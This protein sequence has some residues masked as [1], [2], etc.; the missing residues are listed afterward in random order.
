MAIGLLNQVPYN[1]LTPR[2]IHRIANHMINGPTKT[3]LGYLIDFKRTGTFATSLRKSIISG[4]YERAYLEFI[5][6][7]V[8]PS[9]YVV[10][11]GAHEG[12]I[13]C[14]LSQI[15]EGGKVFSIEPNPENLAFLNRNVKLNSAAN[16]KVIEKAVGKEKAKMP[17]Y[18]STDLGANGS[19]I[20]FSY[21]SQDQVEVDVDTLDN[22]LA[23]LKRLNFLKVDTEGNELDVFLGAQQ[24]LSLHKPHICFEVSL[25]F[26]AYIE[27]SVD[28]L[29]N[30]LKKQ[31]YEL[32]VLKEGRLYEYKWLNERIVNMF[33]IHSSKKIELSEKGII[34]N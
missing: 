12:Y 30:L 24:I 3:R 4:S 32:F 26:W 33:A 15:V 9:D 29:F 20:P 21:F 31:G 18:C 23:D 22:L 11:I 17:F 27:N 5:R 10:D 28:S 1:T 7:L 8:N 14:L 25:T 16:I 19:L 13:S 6:K 34:G 2:I